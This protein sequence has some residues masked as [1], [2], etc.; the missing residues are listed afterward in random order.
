[1]RDLVNPQVIDVFYLQAWVF[2]VDA[3]D[4]V[5]RQRIQ[6]VSHRLEGDAQEARDDGFGGERFRIHRIRGRWRSLNRQ[7]AYQGHHVRVSKDGSPAKEVFPDDLGHVA[8]ELKQCIL[9]APRARLKNLRDL[10]L[11][12]LSAVARK[13]PNGGRAA[14][15]V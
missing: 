7:R 14:V 15:L 10:E 9:L 1:G 5:V 11:L 8:L 3:H 6:E 12:K 13:D 4:A 2:R